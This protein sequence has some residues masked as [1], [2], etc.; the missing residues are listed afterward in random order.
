MSYIG[1]GLLT[2]FTQALVDGLKGRG[3][4]NRNSFIGA[5]SLYEHI[6]ESVRE[7]VQTQI[8]ARALESVRDIL[9]A[10]ASM[11]TAATILGSLVTRARRVA[12]AMW[13]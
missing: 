3:V 11:A 12:Q 8:G 9:G 1:D 6:Y 4:R 2:I 5:N 7:V 13:C 10:G